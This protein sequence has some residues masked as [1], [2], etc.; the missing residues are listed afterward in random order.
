MNRIAN[1]LVMHSR[2]K[3]SLFALPWTIVGSSFVI[4]LFIA[5]LLGGKTAI[6]TGG[7]SSIYIFTLVAGSIIVGGTFPFAVGFGVRRRDYFLGTLTL[8][9][10][11]SAAWAILLLLLSL[12]EADVIKN[13]G[14]GL[15]FFHLPYFSN[16]SAVE[17]FWV[18]F[19]AMLFMF[20]L[21][22]VPGS[23]YQRY[24][25]TG[26]YVLFGAVGLVVS[27]FSL[28]SAYWDWWGTIFGWFARQTAIDLA[29]WTVPL[30]A[31]CALASYTL[32]RRA[33]A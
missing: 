18:Y 26:M 2:D 17:Q 32:L 6:Y 31:L 27:V 13:W 29:W 7:L 8:A 21:G 19:V 3:F 28:V 33:T 10:A 14:V 5:L 25:R 23:V 9:V 16:G 4:N 20:L 1:V 30:I 12:I 22:L 11:I 24:R 15:H